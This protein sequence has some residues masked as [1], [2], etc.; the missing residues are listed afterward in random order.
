[1]LTEIFMSEIAS[2]GVNFVTDKLTKLDI[3]KKITNQI[4]IKTSCNELNELLQDAVKS[5]KQNNIIQSLNNEELESAIRQNI[6]L[7]YDWIITEDLTFDKIS[8][9]L[10][11]PSEDDKKKRI[12]DTFFKSLFS[13]IKDSIVNKPSLLMIRLAAMQKS[14]KRTYKKL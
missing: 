1:M 3:Y 13:Q 2:S 5:A 8:E 10:H 11:Y 9:S 6:E 14:Q 12:F 4:E 7:F